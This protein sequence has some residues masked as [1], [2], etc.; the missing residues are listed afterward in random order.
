LSGM[1][2]FKHEFL[3]DAVSAAPTRSGRS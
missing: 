2:Y 3:G 1:R